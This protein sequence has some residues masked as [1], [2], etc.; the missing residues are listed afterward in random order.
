M[1]VFNDFGILP[2]PRRSFSADLAILDREKVLLAAE[3]KFEPSSKRVD[4]K[5]NKLPV[6]GWSDYLKDVERI[7]RFVEMG[8][9]PVAWAVCVDEGARYVGKPRGS[10]TQVENWDTGYQTQ[11]TLTRWPT[12][13]AP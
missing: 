8:M 2:G 10:F 3:F 11:V 6:I 12:Q 5:A 7:Q 9:T 1:T 4:I 13:G